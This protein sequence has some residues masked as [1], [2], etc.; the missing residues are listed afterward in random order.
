M[1]KQWLRGRRPDKYNSTVG[2]VHFGSLRRVTPISREWG[3]DRG[4]PIDRYYI[5]NFL[6]RYTADVQGRVLE[7]GDNS[8]TRRF[9][10]TRVIMSDVLHV[11]EGNPK[12]TII[13]DLSSADSI[14]S[15]TFDCVILVQTLQL[16]YDVREAVKTIYRILKPGGVLL[17]T[18]PGI[19]QTYDQEWSDS[20]CWSFTTVSARRLFE[21]VFSTPNVKIEAFGNVLTAIS[22]LHGLAVQELSREELD[23][24]EPGYEVTITV[25]TVKPHVSL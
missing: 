20:W 1:V 18:F 10:G 6:E 25:K 9:G 16:I 8:Y 14:S 23:Y 22:F 4:L 7:I 2:E 15:N 24:Y 13:A 3:F 12:A 17:A 19:S 21:E 11:T 5:E